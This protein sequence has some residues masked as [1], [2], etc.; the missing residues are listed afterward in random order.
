MTRFNKG[1]KLFAARESTAVAEKQAIG[2]A[3]AELIHDGETVLLDGGTTT[4]QVA[5]QLMTRSLQVVTNSLPNTLFVNRPF[6]GRVVAIGGVP[7]YSFALESGSLP[8]GLDAIIFD[9]NP[10]P[11]PGRN[12]AAL[13]IARRVEIGRQHRDPPA[14]PLQCQRAVAKIAA[15][16]ASS[17]PVPGR[18][19]DNV[20]GRHHPV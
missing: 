9:A 1:I 4:F 3:A 11:A 6:S 2:Q 19:H 20:S 16:R 12:L 5:R 13:Q 8:P 18:D 7:P 17:A 14:G 15:A 10:R